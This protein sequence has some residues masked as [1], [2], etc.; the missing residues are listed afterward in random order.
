LTLKLNVTAGF[1][2]SDKYTVTGTVIG[3]VEEV[4]PEFVGF[5][6]ILFGL[7]K[8]MKVGRPLPRLIVNEVESLSIMPG[9][10]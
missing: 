4:T 2:E 10:V 7:L 8:V 1:T 5:I 9:S 3:P 6:L